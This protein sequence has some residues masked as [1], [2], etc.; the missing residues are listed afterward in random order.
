[1][2]LLEEPTLVEAIMDARAQ[3]DFLW[4]FF[5]TVHIA[6]FAL[7]FIY[8]HAVERL[9]WPARLLSL[10]GI[11]GFEW[12]NGNALSNAYLMLDAMHEQYRWSFG[13][14]ER[15]NSA[16]Y[17][18]F[19]LADYGDRPSMVILTHSA[20]LVFVILAFLSQRFLQNRQSNEDA[21]RRLARGYDPSD[22]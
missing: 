18:Q 15:F 2:K 17:E 5:V 6:L 20:A 11:S 22:S 12:I 1:M 13:Q 8:G 4:Q 14:V 16:F 19:V 10:F 7:V 3:I 21:A 9:N